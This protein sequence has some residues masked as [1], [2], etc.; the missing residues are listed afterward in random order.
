MV[1]KTQWHQW[2]RPGTMPSSTTRR[3][4]VL[5]QTWKHDYQLSN[6]G[7]LGVLSGSALANLFL[8]GSISEHLIIWKVWLLLGCLSWLKWTYLRLVHN[9]WFFD[10]LRAL[11]IRTTGYKMWKH[12]AKALQSCSQAIQSALERYNTAACLLLTLQC[13]LDW[14]EVVEYAFLADFNLL[15]NA[16]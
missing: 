9:F 13:Q 2:R 1:P 11:V 4:C 16:H 15:R 3:I 6:I 12:I 10:F 8:C 14:K 5:H 7:S